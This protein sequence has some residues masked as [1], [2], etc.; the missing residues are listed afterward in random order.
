MSKYSQDNIPEGG[1]VKHT[2]G[3]YTQIFDKDG[4]LV[5]SEFQAVSSE[6]EDKDGEALTHADPRINFYA[7]F[8]TTS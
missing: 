6:Y 7:P 4:K 1:C 2:E 8:D 5:C 3:T